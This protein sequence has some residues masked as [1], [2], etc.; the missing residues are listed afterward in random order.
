MAE[1]Y[2]WQDLLY[3]WNKKEFEL[4]ELI[5]KGLKPFTEYDNPISFQSIFSESGEKDAA[6][7]KAP[8]WEAMELPFSDKDA[9][10]YF[11]DKTH[12]AN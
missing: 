6:D 2:S 8:A 9:D 10:V 5:K 3:R 1:W 11:V 12:T 4:L 7:E